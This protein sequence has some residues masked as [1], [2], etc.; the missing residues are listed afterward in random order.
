MSEEQMGKSTRLTKCTM[1]FALMATLAG[2][3]KYDN[4]SMFIRGAIAPD[5]RKDCEVAVG[6]LEYL[7]GAMNVVTRSQYF[8]FPHY[9]S[10]LYRH[11]SAF[12]SPPSGNP[13]D[14]LVQGAVIEL[15]QT[16]GTPFV[17]DKDQFLPVLPN[18]FTVSAST[19]IPATDEQV[20][21]TQGGL[22]VIPPQYAE[23][24]RDMYIA[25]YIK[26]G[27]GS[28]AV[29]PTDPTSRVGR[30]RDEDGSVIYNELTVVASVRPFGETLANVSV[31]SDE[32][33]WPIDLCG[34]PYCLSACVAGTDIEASIPCTVGQDLYSLVESG[35]AC[36]GY[37]DPSDNP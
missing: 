32:F 25:P 9:Q 31:E 19:Y 21:E 2:C 30:Q 14:I 13:N 28:I 15:R 4:V 36:D 33:Q 11:G 5:P 1:L 27:D 7:R 12:T 16:D 37:Y 18:P 24:F 29:D 34:D 20:G 8:M 17:F 6:N 3:D 35:P 23:Y 22:E 10:Q 26:A